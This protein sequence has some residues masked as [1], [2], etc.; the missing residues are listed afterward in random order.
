VADGVSE[1]R[2]DKAY[3]IFLKYADVSSPK[4]AADDL[5][6]A[7]MDP[8]VV[9]AV[10][11]KHEAETIRIRNL[12]QPPSVWRDGRVTWYTGPKDTDRNWPAIVKSTEQKNFGAANITS[13]A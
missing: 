11:V 2:V 1:A 6:A 10:R 7:G 4:E 9:E 8:A 12:D 3:K 13:V 5:E